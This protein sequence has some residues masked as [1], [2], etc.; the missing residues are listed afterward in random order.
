[1]RPGG[2][3]DLD[4]KAEKI[5]ELHLETAK[6]DFWQDQTKA[7]ATG[8][9]IEELE[10]EVNEWK[11]LLD[12]VRQFEELISLA[13]KEDDNSLG[14]ESDKTLA[15]LEERFKKLEFFVMFSGVYDEANAILSI[16][17]STGGVE[18]QDWAQMLERMYL[19]FAERHNWQTEIIDR[20]VG[21][22]AGIKSVSILITGRFA[23]G[24]LKAE[25]GSHRLVRMSP[26]NADQKRQTSFAKVEVL[27]QLAEDKTINIKDEDLEISFFRSS[28]PGGQNVN[29]TS[30]AVRLK[31]KPTGIVVSCQSE[32]SQFQNRELAMKMLKAKLLQLQQEAKAEET[33]D[34][35]GEHVTAGW[36][37]NRIRSYVL[38][39]NQL[40]KDERTDF[41]TT[42]FYSVLDGNID[43][44]IEAYLRQKAK[45]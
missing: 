41:E 19:R 2:Y 45:K 26:F 11:K 7:V 37:G 21:N 38:Q 4:R 9:Q 1:L 6:P 28:G 17:S 23:Y 18:A 3:F 43:G 10:S 29:K 20:I 8:Q 34:L 40:V 39:P 5:V 42:D 36:G 22:E 32:R 30:S 33:S 14:D 15:S 35:K 13:N 44:F 31:H 12:D 24:Y 16:H 27:P 25:S